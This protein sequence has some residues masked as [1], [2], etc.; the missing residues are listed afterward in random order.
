MF[1]DH[2]AKM[3]EGKKTKEVFDTIK[4]EKLKLKQRIDEQLLKHVC[5]FD[6]SGHDKDVDYYWQLL[7]KALENGWLAYL[8]HT[9]A[10]RKALI[11]RGK[12]KVLTTKAPKRRAERKQEDDSKHLRNPESRK[13]LRNL[14]Q[15]RRCE[16][17]THRLEISCKDKATCIH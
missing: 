9:G 15:A 1:D 7:S 2:T 6:K 10:T 14:R 17:F 12:V 8:G 4:N 16:Q 13:A 11:G 3:C 5:G